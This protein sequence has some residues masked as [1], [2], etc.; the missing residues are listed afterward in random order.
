MQPLSFV[1]HRKTVPPD[2][3]VSGV[4]R[5]YYI[6]EIGGMTNYHIGQHRTTSD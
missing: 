4:E 5:P 6:L 2:G 1:L 3:I